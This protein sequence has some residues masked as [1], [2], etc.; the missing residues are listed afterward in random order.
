MS[1]Y[2]NFYLRNRKTGFAMSLADYS[3]S[4]PMY[5]CVERCVNC[6]EKPVR[7]DD[8][9]LNEINAEFDEL[10]IE[11]KEYIA[12]AEQRIADLKDVSKNGGFDLDAILNS[13]NEERNCIT[14]IQEELDMYQGQKHQLNFMASF[15]TYDERYN[16]D[17]NEIYFGIEIGTKDNKI[18]G[19]D[20]TED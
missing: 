16:P 17:G 18:V 6:Y 4:N 11:N 5:E 7:L 19:L 14:D 8:D 9:I 10:I 13:I 1:S 15:T 3:R 2:V 12:Q 20:V